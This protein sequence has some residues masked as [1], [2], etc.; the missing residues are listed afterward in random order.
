M[1]ELTPYVPEDFDEFWA[2]T[3]SEANAVRLDYHRSMTNDCDWPGFVVETLSFQGMSHRVHGWIAYP[4]G[5]RRLPGFLWVPPYGRESLLPNKYGTRKGLVSLSINLHGHDAFH[6]EKYTT[7][8]GYFS[9]GSADPHTFVF[10]RMIQDAM[11][12]ARVLQ[13]QIEVDE[14]RIGAMGMSQ[15]G[16]MSIWLG[17]HSP[18]VKAVCADMPFLSAIN[19]TLTKTV[20][21]YPLKEVR[22]FMD[23]IPVG[24]A[25][26]LNTLSYFDTMNQATRCKVPTQVSMGLK[27]PA[28][29]PDVVQATYDALPGEKALRVY[30]WGHDW[31]PDMVENNRQWLLDHLK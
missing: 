8:R 28:C 6:Q 2:E 12:A 30:D 19:H 29:R 25:R 7:S 23:S 5:A 21:R 20:Y 26:V 4:E 16:G 18:V 10:R 9:E 24:E 1:S 3:V 31:H 17:A 13:A 11:I 14:E 27:D 22:D 15:G